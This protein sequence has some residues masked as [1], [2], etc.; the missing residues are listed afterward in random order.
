M[1]DH[2]QI[3]DSLFESLYLV[4]RERKITYWNDAAESLTGYSAEEMVGT[5]C[6]DSPL[7]HVDKKGNNLCRDGCPLSW[8]MAH[9]TKHE[10]EI[11]LRHKKGYRI[12]I[13]VR[14]SPLYDNNGQVN[15]A[16][17][18]F[19]DNTP[20][21]SI[22]D[23]ISE[24]EELAML[25][26][27]TKLANGK[28]AMSQVEQYLSEMKRYPVKAGVA[29]FKI[30]GIN[31]LL[32]RCGKEVFDQLQVI[33]GQTLKSNT[34]PLDLI[35]RIDEGLFLGLFRNVTDNTLH[36]TCEKMR[37]LFKQ[38]Y[39]YAEE[40]LISGTISVGGRCLRK[41]DEYASIISHGMDYLKDCQLEG[42]DRTKIDIRL[43][44]K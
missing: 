44:A 41:E 15:G 6:Y 42:G 43:I 24:L 20:T 3:L 38:S 19:R 21:G 7:K 9:K 1:T 16:S 30:D 25:D 34:R 8:A 11:F 33:T 18:L 32:K 14:V 4:T 37:L 28:F 36:A 13:N 10:D 35:A 2:R 5:H 23:R 29:L 22:A 39:F 27:L 40:E 12:P 31:V 26:P 17:E